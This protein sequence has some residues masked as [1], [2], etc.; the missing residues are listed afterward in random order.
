MM[1]Q[2]D[3]FLSSK[4]NQNQHLEFASVFHENYIKKY[5]ETNSIF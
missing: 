4:T 2:K 3:D 5:I 1:C